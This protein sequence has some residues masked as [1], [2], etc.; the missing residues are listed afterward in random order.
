MLFSSPASSRNRAPR[1][2]LLALT[3][4]WPPLASALDR[5]FSLL[6]PPFH[7]SIAGSHHQLHPQS[8]DSPPWPET[9]SFRLTLLGRLPFR[10]SGAR[11]PTER[12]EKRETRNE[13]QETRNKTRATPRLDSPRLASPPP[14]SSQIPIAFLVH[15][16]GR[17]AA[18]NQ[19]PA[20]LSLSPSNTAASRVP[21]APWSP[22]RARQVMAPSPSFS[23]CPL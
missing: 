2:P 21:S 10:L 9:P 3:T 13:K 1:C 8:R 12:D 17:A 5:F 11:A 7:S 18:K 22:F 16:R 4:L 19:Q 15:S 14:P 20:S 23:F 6:F